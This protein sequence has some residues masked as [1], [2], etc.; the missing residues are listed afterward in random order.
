MYKPWEQ[1]QMTREEWQQYQ[2]EYAAWL[3]SFDFIMT[4]SAIAESQRIGYGLK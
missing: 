4:E 3:K 2:V 1:Y